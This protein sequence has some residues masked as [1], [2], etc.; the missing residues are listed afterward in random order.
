MNQPIH[1]AYWLSRFDS[2]L[3]SALAQH[4]AVSFIRVDLRFP[5]YMPATIM[6]SGPDSAVISR[7][8]ASL[9]AKIQ[10]YQ[11][12]KRRA[13]QR[14]H[15]T[16]LRYFWCREFGE[17]ENRKHYHVILLLNKDTWCSLGDF[18]EPSSLAAMIQEAWCSALH[19]EPWQGDGLVHFSRWKPFRK[20]ASSDAPPSSADTPLP[21][22]C[23]D[24]RKA[25]DKKPGEAA[26][27]WIK[28]GDVAAMQK[29][30][31][32]ALYLVKY[33]TKQHDGSGQ[34]N[35][36]CSRGPGRLLDGR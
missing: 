7:F 24:T 10:A 8:F 29:A 20:P 28:R 25:A 12:H 6:D 14:V 27:L 23:T 1:N 2:L 30:R 11:Q 15:A 18:S 26:V 35:Y 9:K 17:E 22:G 33:E 4:R 36:G 31:N 32:R 21:G 3:D 13:S 16:S 19:L 5:E 34:R